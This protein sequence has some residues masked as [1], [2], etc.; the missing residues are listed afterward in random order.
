[1]PQP[2]R[3]FQ[4]HVRR[5]GRLCQRDGTSQVSQA[6]RHPTCGP[7]SRELIKAHER[8]PR[9]ES[10]AVHRSLLAQS[11]HSLRRKFCPLSDNNGQRWILA[12]DGLSANDLG[13][14]KTHTSEKCRK[15]NSPTWH[16]TVCPQHYQFS[17]RAIS[18]K[19]FYA[20]GGRATLSSKK[21]RSFG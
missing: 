13:C 20:R 1:M 14:V 17:Y 18:Q 15:Y 11:G 5:S 9:Q 16:P 10:A 3:G 21:P 8:A 12:G 6:H 2:L 7:F 4:V 19:Y